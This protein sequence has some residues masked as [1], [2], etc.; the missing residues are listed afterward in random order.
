MYRKATA[1]ELPPRIGFLSPFA[2]WRSGMAIFTEGLLSA[3]TLQGASCR[4]FAVLESGE[5]E[6]G[7]HRV[8]ASMRED[9]PDEYR[10]MAGRINRAGIDVLNV[11]Y[12]LHR[13]GG[14]DADL[15]LD[16]LDAVEVPVTTSLH[17]VP[18]RPSPPSL[19][20]LRTLAERSQAVTVANA[21]ARDL[22]VEHYGID[23]DKISLL[24]HGAPVITL[25]NPLLLKSRLGL[26]GHQVLLSFGL[27]DELKGIE[28][29]IYALPEIVRRH[30]ETL[31][32]IVGQTHPHEKERQSERY[33]TYL[34]ELA[35]SLGV[36]NY[37]R[38]VDGYQ[39]PQVLLQY[40]QA[41]D[42]CLLPYLS[43]D[44]ATSGTLAYA[45]ACGRPTIATAFQHARHLLAKGR[46]LLVPTAD[47]GAITARTLELLDHPDRAFLMEM[48]C[49]EYGR[50]LS[51][52]DVGDRF[53]DLC[54]RLL[55]PP[56]PA[57]LARR[58]FAMTGRLNA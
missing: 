23:P 3:A 43:V 25:T 35:E 9:V 33:R 27:I 36:R 16:L 56:P 50:T 18:A 48:A 20:Y 54:R 39:S 37:I 21:I 55:A 44:Q 42:I 46:G 51:W 26:F 10:L 32:C 19:R 13:Y 14:L 7:D 34:Q 5:V 57:R 53:V 24:P 2:A 58:V 15:L 12:D 47:S 29:A 31:Y 4:I 1:S 28:Y 40:L 30:P 52:I 6:S 17:S 41:A 38:F 22:L 49:R 8:T 11:Q 45:V